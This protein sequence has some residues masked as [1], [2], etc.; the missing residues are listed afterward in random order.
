M[1]RQADKVQK[2]LRY[3]GSLIEAIAACKA[4]VRIKEDTSHLVIKIP[5]TS[6]CFDLSPLA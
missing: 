2:S 5:F 3:I 1:H 6:L 4:I